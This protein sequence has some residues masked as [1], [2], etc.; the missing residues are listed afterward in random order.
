MNDNQTPRIRIEPPRVDTDGNGAALLMQAYGVRLDP[1]Q[2]LVCDAILGKDAAGNYTTTS[3][4]ISV[5]RQNGKSE[6][7][8]AICFYNLLIN[9]M[10]ILFTA[11]RQ[12]SVKKIF[13]RLVSMFTDKKHKEIVQAVKQIRYGIGEESIE[14][15]NGGLIE[16]TSR[17]RQVAR[18]YDAISLVIYDEAQDL[19]DEQAAAIMATLSASSTGI[20]QLIYAGTPPYTGCS[21][22]VF[23]R[24]RQAC[25][26][27]DGQGKNMRN[28]WHEWSPDA[29]SLQD[30]DITNR[31]L[32][33]QCNPAMGTRLTMEFTEEELKTLSKI[34]F[35]RERLNFWEKEPTKENV[36]AIS[37]DVWDACSSDEEHKEGKTAY[38][39]KFTADGAE[40]VLAGAV[41]PAGGEPARIALIAV[42]PTGAG[43]SWLAN[44]LNERYKKASC[45]VIDG[46]NGTDVLIEK[47]KPAGGGVWAFKDSI[48]KP[49]A[50]DIVTAANIRESAIT[51]IKRPISGGFGFGGTGS[52]LIE[53][54]SLA[55]WGC[56]ISKRNPQK[57]M[58]IG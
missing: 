51:A 48:I 9:G 38:G 15:N 2:G 28:S 22:E 35:A 34:D 20:R 3:A 1:W 5:A 23:A 21:G 52:A 10:R 27:S 25:I 42:E 57:Q 44:W 37:P 12:R 14:L 45:V 50:P 33:K 30:I 58:R 47:L 39:V 32:W 40:V 36:L 4:G 31:E 56:R 17:S 8:I 26:L 24:F 16:F 11:H 49:K 41:I 53:A 55:L 54:C 46:R 43:L 13:F 7:L 29:D 6:I 19:T 18:G